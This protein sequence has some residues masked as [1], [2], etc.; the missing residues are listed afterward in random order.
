VIDCLGEAKFERNEK[1]IK[2]ETQSAGLDAINEDD[3]DTIPVPDR[4]ARP[5]IGRKHEH[6]HS[7]IGFGLAVKEDD[8]QKIILSHVMFRPFCHFPSFYG[9]QFTYYSY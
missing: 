7:I 2:C 8:T 4:S 5:H 6:R 1:K 9:R 3:S